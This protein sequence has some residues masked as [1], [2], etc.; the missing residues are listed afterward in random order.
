MNENLPHKIIEGEDFRR[1]QLI[2]LDLMLEVDRICRK[3]DIKYAICAGTLL[4]A[5][6]HKGFIPWDDDADLCMLREDYERFREIAQEEMDPEFCWFQDNITDPNYPWS[7]GKVRR[8]GTR[9]VRVGYEQMDMDSG[10]F[11]DIFPLDDIP[12]TY[13]GQW[14]QDKYCFCLRKMMYAV[15]AKD[16]GDYSPLTRAW[17]GLLYK[18]PRPWVQKRIRAMELKSR[19]DS[20]NYVRTL[21]FPAAGRLYEE[22]TGKGKTRFGTPKEWGLD[23]AEYEFEGHMFYGMR[24]Y[25]TGLTFQY[26]DW[27]A[28]PPEDKREPHHLVIDYEF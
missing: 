2:E 8:T 1:M 7:F 25:E 13:V 24:D 18:I 3:H 20:P 26:G 12:L 28:L 16:R 4:G 22:G 10:V 19:N 6:R 17:Y 23:L 15:V 9:F 27:R 14:I 21:M 5:V 11:I